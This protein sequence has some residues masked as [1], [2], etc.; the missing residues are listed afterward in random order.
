ME[1]QGSG[2]HVSLIEPGA[3][4]SRFTANALSKIEENVDLV[5]SV[6]AVE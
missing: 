1:L 6:H 4:A 3:I 2:I 5:N